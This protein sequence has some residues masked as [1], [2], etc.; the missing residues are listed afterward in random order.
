[1]RPVPGPAPVTVLARTGCL[2]EFQLTDEAFH[3]L[4]VASQLLERRQRSSRHIT[5]EGTL[6]LQAGGL[7]ARLTT[8]LCRDITVAKFREVQTKTE[9]TTLA[10]SSEE[11]DG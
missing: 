2:V 1:M 6:I 8:V 9:E 5:E 3:L 7:D 10:E 11:G 4:G